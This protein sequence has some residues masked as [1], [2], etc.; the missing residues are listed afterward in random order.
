MTTTAPSYRHNHFVPEWYQRG[1]LLP[2]QGEHFVFDKD[3]DYWIEIPGHRRKKI[4]RRAVTRKGPIK[5]L[6]VKDLYTTNVFGLPNTE[7]ERR[8][9]G[10]IDTCGKRACELFCAWPNNAGPH[11]DNVPEEFGDPCERIVD[12]IEYLDAQKLR[13]PKGLAFLK[14]VLAKNGI[15]APTQNSLMDIMQRVRQYFATTWSEGL[16]ELVSAEESAT[17]FIFSDDPVTLYNCDCFPGAPQCQYPYD[18]HPYFVGTRTIFPLDRNNC[19]IIANIEHSKNPIRTNARKNRRNARSFDQTLI[20]YLDIHKNRSLS[21]VDVA[22]INYIIK[23]RAI[24]YIAAGQ[25]DWLYP[26]NVIGSVKWPELDLTLQHQGFAMKLSSQETMVTYE[27]ESIL[28]VTP[29]G[30]RDLVPGWFVKSRRNK[31]K[32]CVSD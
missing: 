26:E 10:R 18:P 28:T 8:L 30:E 4:I 11:G 23:S 19:L 15:L 29:Y 17:K 32:S 7:I 9:F 3:P 24:R 16:W 5:F 6:R 12:L 31:N 14:L 25:E 1:F 27:D 20:T 22:T 13:T 21:E 2:G